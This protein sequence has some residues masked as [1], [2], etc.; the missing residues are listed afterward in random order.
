MAIQFQ[1]SSP[2]PL[3]EAWPDAARPLPPFVRD[4][5]ERGA[6]EGTRNDTIFKAAQQFMACGYSQVEAEA[7]IVR[8]A[9]A[10]GTS[11]GEARQAIKSA[12]KSTAVTEPITLAAGS[13]NG[14]TASKKQE[15]DTMRALRAA[16]LPGESIAIV[17]S[18]ENDAGEWKPSVATIKTLEQ[19]GAWLAKM[20]SIDKLFSGTAGGAFIGINPVKGG[21]QVRSNDNV[22]AFRHVLV[23]WDDKGMSLAEQA[24]KIE[25]SGLPV[26]VMLT[27]GGK[28]VHA[29]VRVDAKDAEEWKARRDFLF[30]QFQCDPKN[31]DLARV[32]RCP[33]AM[34][35]DKEQKVLAVGLGPKTW[36]EWEQ[37]NEWVPESFGVFDLVERG[38]EPPPEVIKGVL[39]RGCVMQISSGP[40]MRKSY[41]LIDLAFSV[42]AGIPWLGL[43]TNPGPVF[44]LDAENQA[45]LIRER[46]PKVAAA[47]GVKL[48]PA[49]NSRF[50]IC[51]LRWKLK[52]KSLPDIVQ[53]VT[54]AMRAMPVPPVLAILEPLYLLLRGAKEKE[55]EEV[56]QALEELDEL[57][58]EVGCAIA[59]VH[60]FSK[61]SQTG[62][63]SMDRASGSGALSRFPDAIVTLTPPDEPKSDKQAKPDWQ[64]TVG[65]DLRWFPPVTEFKVWWKGDH[66]EAS[67]KTTYVVKAHRPGSYADKYGAILATM[68]KLKRHRDDVSQCDVTAWCASAFKLELKEARNAFESL[69]GAEYNFVRS[70][71]DGLWIGASVPDDTDDTAPF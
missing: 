55:A 41:L 8:R 70:L 5:I 56:T 65:M 67:P 59:F 2:K 57:C 42:Q 49:I 28:S 21:A 53:G 20:G 52:G 71:G 1:A 68:P 34:R 38:P 48:S 19:W 25:A 62:K 13:K 18:R 61:G 3:V 44:Y 26:S 33:G 46:L 39:R 16:F 51:P 11:D 43:E 45:A 12:F 58:R 54:R 27:S 47:R 60:H 10:D 36:A 69:R 30:E 6:P 23:E 35:G 63:A 7:Y 66:Y 22:A 17:E 14:A 29:W 24:S 40:K 9:I 32:S 50:V 4:Y 37:R 31:K 15:S 64:A